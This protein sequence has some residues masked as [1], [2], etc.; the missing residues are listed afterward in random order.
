MRAHARLRV[1]LERDR[2]GGATTRVRRLRSEGPISL[3]PTN[4]LLPG[5]AQDWG[6]SAQEA[7]TVRSM[8]AAAGPLGG[9]DW[10]LEI[11]V[12]EGATL[13]LGAVAATIILPG[14]HGGESRSDV[15]ISVAQGGTLIWL[16]GAQIAARGCRHVAFNRIDLAE[17]ARLYAHEEILLGRH[18]EDPGS[19]RQRLRVAREGVPLY[20]QEIAVGPE[21]PGW[22]ST[23]VTGRRRALGTIL[24]VDTDAERLDVLRVADPSTN[25]D[26]AVM[27]LDDTA[28]I[29]TSL[30]QDLTQLRQ[31]MGS[32]DRWPR[33]GGLSAASEGARE[34]RTE[35]VL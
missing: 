29:V 5:W 25:P 15:T 18:R 35:M 3:R 1:E 21:S 24:V 4:E 28:A 2:Y 22:A 6:A 11:E 8:A 26:T 14:V 17:G 9:D 7:A 23:A 16:P 13:L 34:L 32:V 10:T 12:A 33:G 31:N 20:D 30:A 19:F 27:R